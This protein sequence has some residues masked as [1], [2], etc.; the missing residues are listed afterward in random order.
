M[1][2][3]IL[4]KE[5]KY[6]TIGIFEDLEDKR[7]TLTLDKFVQFVEGE[8]ERMYHQTL[9]NPVKENLSNIKRVAIL[10]G[11]DGLLAR[12]LLN[13]NPDLDIVLVDMD[14]EVVNLCKTYPRIKEINQGSLDRIKII[15]S[16]AKI[17]VLEQGKEFDAVIADFPDP[18][19][20]ELKT[21]YSQPFLDNIKNI[22]KK[23]G[24]FTTQVGLRWVAT[25]LNVE[26]VFGAAHIIEYV[27]PTL[28][29]AVIVWAKNG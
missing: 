23:E 15:I 17:W 9:A 6:Q 12:E 4:E 24:I 26:S 1:D 20:E 11:G 7:L 13:I 14:S 22:L 27:M 10:G 18:N 29:K 8:D 19:S 28:G 21:L 3:L 2:R 16:D 5:T 25:Y